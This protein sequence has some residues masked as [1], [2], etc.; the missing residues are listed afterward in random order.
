MMP[1]AI[2]RTLLAMRIDLRYSRMR[3]TK[4][5]KLMATN[6]KYAKL[7]NNS[8]KISLI[9]MFV[10]LFGIVAFSSISAVLYIIPIGVSAWMLAVSMSM[11]SK[12]NYIYDD[13]VV[14]L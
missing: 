12:A 6:E 2:D 3:Q 14:P 7:V 4:H 11:M 9:A 10:L 8:S 5:R 13:E 1:A